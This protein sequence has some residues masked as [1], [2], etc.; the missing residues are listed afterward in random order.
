ML[1]ARLGV[2]PQ[3]VLIAGQQVHQFA[4][5][6]AALQFVRRFPGLVAT[7]CGVLR[8]SSPIAVR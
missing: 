4:M 3:P 8:A 6:A 2:T 7:S 5:D 1:A